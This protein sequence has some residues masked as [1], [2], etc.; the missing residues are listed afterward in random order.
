LLFKRYDINNDGKIRFSEFADAF[1]PKDKIYADHLNNK[2]SNYQA[3]YPEE[4]FSVSTKY[5][6]ADLIRKMLRAES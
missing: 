4:A 5:D 6:F 2:R 3:R 1:T